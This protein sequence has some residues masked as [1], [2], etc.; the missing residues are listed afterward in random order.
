MPRGIKFMLYAGWFMF[1]FLLSV[2]LTLPLC[3]VKRLIADR[4]EVE[5][6]KGNSAKVGP[7]GI[8]PEVKIKDL[9]IYRF[10]GLSL[11]DLRVRLASKN[12]DLGSQFVVDELNIR[13][14]LLSL[15]TDA[16][17]ISFNG[18]AYEGSFE[19]DVEIFDMGKKTQRVESVDIEV[20]D[21]NLRKIDVIQSAFN[22]NALPPEGS[23]ESNPPVNNQGLD[24]ILELDI[25]LETGADPSKEAE[26]SI[27]G[28]IEKMVAGPTNKL[29][30]PDVPLPIDIP[31]IDLG[32]LNIDIGVAKGKLASRDLSISG[33]NLTVEAELESKLTKRIGASR[34][35]GTGWGKI[36][37]SF[38]DKKENSSLKTKIDMASQFAGKMKDDEGRYHFKVN[39][40][41]QKPRMSKSRAGAKARPKK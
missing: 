9:S 15:L 23:D 12:Q 36:D 7:H 27:K 32:V 8:D 4:M 18:E 41:L 24:G 2:Y 6:G 16:K 31:Q 29:S 38:L 22:V 33:G 40:T 10:S 13:V 26:G 34:L 3:S 21:V 1:V 17:S 14:G 20:D 5:L 37:Q 11:E 39:G 35:N 30:L 28:K 25:E 19:G